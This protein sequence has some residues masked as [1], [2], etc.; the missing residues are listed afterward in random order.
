MSYI[1]KKG[2]VVR[3]KKDQISHMPGNLHGKPD[4]QKEFVV[5][6]S[7]YDPNLDYG[8]E[9]GTEWSLIKFKGDKEGAGC[10]SYRLELV[11]KAPKKKKP[12]PEGNFAWGVFYLDGELRHAFKTRQAARD[13]NKFGCY[14]IKKIKYEIV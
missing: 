11:E 4:A 1:F 6:D 13:F 7:D 2:D 8:P 14:Q 9:W 10:L 5:E 12:K 3:Y